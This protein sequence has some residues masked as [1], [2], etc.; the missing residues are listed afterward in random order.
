M[1]SLGWSKVPWGYR[2]TLLLETL[3]LFPHSNAGSC[4]SASE[5]LWLIMSSQATALENSAREN[6]KVDRDMLT[7]MLS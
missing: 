5:E 2:P 7:L 1:A 4:G 6:S 3:K